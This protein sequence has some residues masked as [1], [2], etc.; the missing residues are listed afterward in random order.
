MSSPSRFLQE[1]NRAVK[2][3][4]DAG[5]NATREF[6]EGILKEEEGYANETEENWDQREAMGG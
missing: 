5:D 1:L 6:L 3:A 4:A 2:L